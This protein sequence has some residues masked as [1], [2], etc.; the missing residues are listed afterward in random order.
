MRIAEVTEGVST[1]WKRTTGGASR[2]F[3]CK[4]GPRKGRVMA[5]PAA[6]NAPINQK[7]SAGL[8]KTKTKLG[9]QRSFKSKQ[10]RRRNPYSRRLTKLNKRKR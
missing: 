7:K 3:R 10:T 1:A 5:S 2:K 6:C 9:K 8:K 4:S